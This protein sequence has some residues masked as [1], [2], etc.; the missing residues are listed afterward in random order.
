MKSKYITVDK[1]YIINYLYYLLDKIDNVYYQEVNTSIKR[2]ILK[3]QT[4]T[5]LN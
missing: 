1:E 4:N 5:F 2:F 3:L